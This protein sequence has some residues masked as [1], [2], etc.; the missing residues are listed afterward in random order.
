MKTTN[1]YREHFTPAEVKNPKNEYNLIWFGCF[2]T[3]TIG[4]IVALG[5]LYAYLDTRFGSF[6]ALGLSLLAT[7]V[8]YLPY[9]KAGFAMLEY[10]Q[11]K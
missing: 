2:W 10:F 4:L 6:A 8:V 9:K 3:I 1:A 7:A 11:S 5:N